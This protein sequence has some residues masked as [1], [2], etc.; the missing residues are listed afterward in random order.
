MRGGYLA[1]ALASALALSACGGEDSG[2][3]AGGVSASSSPKK[4]ADTYISEMDNIAD[5]LESMIESDDPEAAAKVIQD[6]TTTLNALS[7]SMEGELSGMKAM[8]IYG[9]RSED[10]MRVQQR[11]AMSMASLA[12]KDPMMLQRIQEEMNKLPIGN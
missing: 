8:Q 7:D 5:A 11:I 2:G 10:F 1:I 9:A 12:Q 6:A 4:I 3:D